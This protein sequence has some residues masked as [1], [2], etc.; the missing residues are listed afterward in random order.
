MNRGTKQQWAEARE[1]WIAGEST[2]AIARHVGT[3]DSTVFYHVKVEGWPRRT[4][5]RKPDHFD[6]AQARKLWESGANIASIEAAVGVRRDA[7]YRAAL[8]QRWARRARVRVPNPRWTEARE[9]WVR[10]DHAATIAAFVGVSVKRV[11]MVKREAGWP[12]RERPRRAPRPKVTHP[13]KPK[14]QHVVNLTKPPRAVEK[15]KGDPCPCGS[16]LSRLVLV[17]NLYVHR[18]VTCVPEWWARPSAGKAAA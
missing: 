6:H 2:A 14:A 12:A 9:M 3:A 13:R 15:I 1:M 7:I 16:H 4:P 11:N 5:P 8:R 10:G 18:C 17:N